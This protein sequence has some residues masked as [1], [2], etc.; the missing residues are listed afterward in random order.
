MQV[1]HDVGNFHTLSSHLYKNQT[2]DDS[3]T[4]KTHSLLFHDQIISLSFLFSHCASEIKSYKLYMRLVLLTS[5]SNGHPLHS[6]KNTLNLDLS[7]VSALFVCTLKS[8]L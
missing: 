6:S 7:I 2:E 4:S 8:Y 1:L 3:L 5:K